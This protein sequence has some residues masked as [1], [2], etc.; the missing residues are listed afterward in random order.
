MSDSISK[1]NQQVALDGRNSVIAKLKQSGINIEENE[2]RKKLL[3]ASNP[4]KSRTVEIR[5]KTKRGKGNWHSNTNEAKAMN[6]LPDPKDETA[7]WIFVNLNDYKTSAQFWIVPDSWMR[8]DIHT[9]HEEYLARYGGRRAEND[10]S[11]H[12]SISEGRLAGWE[13]RWEI[14]DLLQ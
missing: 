13:N 6:N 1:S 3:T 14:L 2:G 9:A 4:N 11:D 10:E 12:H 7:F 5:V 8:N